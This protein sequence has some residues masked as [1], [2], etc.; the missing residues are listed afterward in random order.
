MKTFLPLLILVWIA[1]LLYMHAVL[2]RGWVPHDEGA[3]AQAAERVLQGELPHRDFD[4]IYTGGLALFDALAFRAFGVNLASLRWAMF[5]LFAAWV[6]VVYYVAS[7]F[8]SPLASAGVTL[9]SVA[10]SVP[11][12]AAPVPSWYNLF[13]AMFGAASLLRYLEKERARWLV[14]AGMCGG[15]SCLAKITGLYYIAAALLF[16]IFREQTLTIANRLES[17]AEPAQHHVRFYSVAVALCLVAFLGIV[18]NTVHWSFDLHVCI[19]FEIPPLALV[20]VLLWRETTIKGRDDRERFALLLKMSLLFLAG[21]CIPVAAFLVPYVAT[22]SL[23]S[24]MHGV[25]I[26]PGKRLYYAAMRPTGLHPLQVLVTLALV[27]LLY[28]TPALRGPLSRRVQLEF[29]LFLVAAIIFSSVS[30][31]V[32]QFVWLSVTLLIPATV[33]AAGV[34]LGWDRQQASISPLRQQQLFMSSAI[35]CL[36]SLVQFPFSA[37]IYLCYVTPLLILAILAVITCSNR[38]SAFVHGSLL[39]FYMAFGVLYTTPGF[40]YMLGIKPD[41]DRQTYRLDLARSGN[42]KVSRETAAEYQTLIP[43][44]QRHAQG[45]YIYAAPD[46]PEV[47]FLSGLKNP[48]RTIFDFFD[49]PSGHTQ[50]IMSEIEGHS[51]NEVVILADPPFS[52]PVPPDLR[53]ELE[54]RFRNR[55]YA[56]HFE[57]RWKE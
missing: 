13:F 39:L 38:Q 43:L 21:V 34:F 28:V 8:A 22:H 44:V 6:P 3:L 40:I 41:S 7:R 18:F 14:I 51:V 33:V 57:V 35:V 23:P 11:N 16:F 26:M 53:R 54:Q 36:C 47:Y 50:R 12:Y 20:L 46:C 55:S 42:L 27:A 19:Q 48:T 4:D 5:L 29:L 30:T 25:F 15:L 10:W 56:G 49:N 1:S 45:R 31:L 37:P 17:A 9:L 32:Y 24:L 2:M 52:P